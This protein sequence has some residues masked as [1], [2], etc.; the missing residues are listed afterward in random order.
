M[1][2]YYISRIIGLAPFSLP[3]KDSVL[4]TTILDYTIVIITGLLYIYFFYSNVVYTSANYMAIPSQSIL[5]DHIS[6]SSLFLF[7]F[8]LLLSL[9]L[10]VIFG[11]T[12][13]KIIHLINECD[14]KVHKLVYSR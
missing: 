2:I 1:P 14:E 8:F 11:K 7:I 13:W 9:F 12:N 4:K 10:S 6:T 3:S 5:F